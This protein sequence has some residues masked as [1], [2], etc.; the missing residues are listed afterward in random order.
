MRAHRVCEKVSVVSMEA[1]LNAVILDSKTPKA[2][3]SS[4]FSEADFDAVI[5]RLRE[6][7]EAAIIE[8]AHAV[9]P[10]VASYADKHDREG[11]YPHEAFHALW[12]AGLTSLSL[13]VELGGVG[14]TFT[15]TAK[16]V[17]IIAAA[18][19][20][21]AFILKAHLSGLR[22]GARNW[23]EPVRT[24]FL[25]GLR[26]GP[27]HRSGSRSDKKGGS[28][29]RG[30]LP[31]CTARLITREDGSKGWKIN[32]HKTYATHSVGAGWFGVW[33]ATH[34]DDDENGQIRVGTFLVPAD[35]PGFRVVEGSWDQLGM[36]GTVSNDLI[37]EDVIIPYDYALG[38]QPFNTGGPE[39]NRRLSAA[40][41]DWTSGLEAAVYS[42]LAIAARDFLA[43][44]LHERAPASLGAPL[45]T[46]PRFQE[47]VGE[48]DLLIY[49]SQLVI[50]ELSRRI[51]LQT[52]DPEALDKPVSMLETGLARVQ[53]V[54]NSH[55]AID[56][57][58]TLTGNYGLSRHLPLQR[59]FRDVLCGRVHE[60][61]ADVLLTARG[62]QVLGLA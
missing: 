56:L 24:Q 3:A 19:G 30:G 23:P 20:S 47:A 22:D 1:E 45:A 35:T 52:R 43:R 53:A 54:R 48:I 39:G 58:L 21:T 62:K 27:I 38:L 37:L 57:A 61:M 8:A 60:P 17:R 13:P 49:N 34:P 46:L 26:K 7:G 32:G 36:R 6:G 12:E 28:P 29:A 44:Y 59:Y 4:S 41:I 33:G 18:D 40:L 9:A 25:E 11:T 31:G 10:V 14:A 42:G 51:D 50:D 5:T 2:K 15:A 16:A 55:K